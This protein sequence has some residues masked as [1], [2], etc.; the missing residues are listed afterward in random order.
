MRP[1]QTWSPSSPQ[2]TWSGIYSPEGLIYFAPSIEILSIDVS[3]NNLVGGFLATTKIPVGTD[4]VL[5]L[6]GSTIITKNVQNRIYLWDTKSPDS[7]VELRSSEIQV[8]RCQCPFSPWLNP[9][10]QLESSLEVVIQDRIIIVMRPTTL[11]I[12]AVPS[13]T[14]VKT[15][16]PVAEHRWPWKLDSVS[17]VPR[18][19]QIGAPLGP[20]PSINVLVRYGS[21]LPWVWA[22]TRINLVARI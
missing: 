9:C 22:C 14:N 5:G 16:V 19:A 20:H 21:L 11:D 15:I 10:D 2:S 7:R 17:V 3:G 18:N 12:Y 4:R 8:M 1:V 6:R 13:S